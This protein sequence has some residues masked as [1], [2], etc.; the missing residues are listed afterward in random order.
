MY[1]LA[2]S[3]IAIIVAL[4]VTVNNEAYAKYEPLMSIE[5]YQAWSNNIVNAC[6]VP[7]ETIFPRIQ[8]VIKSVQFNIDAEKNSSLLPDTEEVRALNQ[9]RDLH[10]EVFTFLYRGQLRWTYEKNCLLLQAQFLNAFNNEISNRRS[11]KPLTFSMLVEWIK[12]LKFIALNGN[13]DFKRSQANQKYNE[14]ITRYFGSTNSEFEGQVPDELVQLSR[15]NL[16]WDLAELL[17]S[18]EAEKFRMDASK[19]LS[20]QSE[21]TC[22]KYQGWDFKNPT[23]QN[24]ASYA[25]SNSKITGI[26]I[27]ER[28]REYDA[29]I[30]AVGESLEKSFGK[31]SVTN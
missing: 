13:T 19:I 17:G 29:S 24:Y 25:C 31:P 6:S 3:Y 7:S 21:D 5:E 16:Y 10:N 23:L 30:K 4:V 1:T 8:D 2:K 22:L 14:L 12:S 15:A 9:G 28:K 20:K 18:E 27:F 11:G 26:T